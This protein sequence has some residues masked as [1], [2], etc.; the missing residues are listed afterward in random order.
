M[1]TISFDTNRLHKRTKT[2]ILFYLKN[3]NDNNNKVVRHYLV[4]ILCFSIIVV[5][6]LLPHSVYSNLIIYKYIY[7]LFDLCSPEVGKSFKFY[8]K[9][10]R[11]L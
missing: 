2:E 7:I 9:V 1:S 11:I 5:F 8:V 6:I 10:L 3:N 4:L